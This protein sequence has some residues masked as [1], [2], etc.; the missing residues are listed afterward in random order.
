MA[1]NQWSIVRQ[2]LLDEENL[3][4][5]VADRLDLPVSHH[6]LEEGFQLPIIKRCLKDQLRLKR[7]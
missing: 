4:A 3:C 7:Q 6:L 5:L 1:N 2:Q